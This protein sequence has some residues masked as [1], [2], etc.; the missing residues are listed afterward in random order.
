MGEKKGGGK[1]NM[2]RN[3][4]EGKDQTMDGLTLIK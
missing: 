1:E 4:V 2:L 3:E